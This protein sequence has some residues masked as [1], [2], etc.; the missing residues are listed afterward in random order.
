MRSSSTVLAAL[1][2]Q[3]KREEDDAKNTGQMNLFDQLKH[4]GFEGKGAH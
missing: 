3:K 1:D 4:R 2:E